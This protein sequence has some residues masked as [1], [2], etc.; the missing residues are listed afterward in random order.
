MVYDPGRYLRRWAGDARRWWWIVLA[1]A[2]VGAIAGHMLAPRIQSFRATTTILAG[3]P[4]DVA[5]VQQDD[6]AASDDTARVLAEMVPQQRVLQA[7]AD[8]LSLGDWR[9]LAGRVD[10]NVIGQSNRL[11]GITVTAG[12]PQ[13]A[14]AVAG[15]IPGQLA[16]A[17]FPNATSEDRRAFLWSRID[18][19]RR[20]IDATQRSIG[21]LRHR[22]HTDPKDRATAR[23]LAAAN[24]LL[25][26]WDAS[27]ASIY[28]DL[29]GATSVDHLEVLDAPA[30]TAGPFPSEV[31]IDLAVGLVAAIVGSLLVSVRAWRD[32]G[33][34]HD[35]A[36]PAFAS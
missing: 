18:A 1:C 2:V 10:A 33:R 12:S 20:H 34:A 14:T 6:I 25:E 15:A 7:V 26:G 4:T 27:L 31:R 36:V 11:I 8:Q 13:E 22:L 35:A 19:I 24:A 21:D 23:R 5:F 9:V 17:A 16:Q 3:V 29:Q 30:V 32:Q 28:R